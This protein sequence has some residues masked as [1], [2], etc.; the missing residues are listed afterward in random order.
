LL[1]RKHDAK[2]TARLLMSIGVRSEAY[3]SLVEF[4][5]QDQRSVPGCVIIDARLFPLIE[6]E[7]AIAV[8]APCTCHPMIVTA[9]SAEIPLVVRAMKAGAVDFLQEPFAEQAMLH[10]V[11]AAL[12]CDRKHRAIEQRHADLR[13]R[14]AALT[15]RERQ[16][17]ALVT[18]GRL[19][20]QIAFDLGL[21]EIT[22]KVHRGSV[23]RK[24]EA[25]SVAELVRMA[26]AI[27]E[28]GG[29]RDPD[30]GDGE[31]AQS[32]P[33]APALDW[34]ASDTC[35]DAVEFNQAFAATG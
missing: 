14:F 9:S 7:D 25:R 20:K 4:R 29:W 3:V 28:F 1:Q 18:A 16:V 27:R 5:A 2:R 31:Q 24:M 13:R 30:A 8:H 23:M 10:A 34:T 19:N 33:A 32:V 15:P 26:D 6:S 17:M 35:G 12:Q 21:S 22:V 11:S